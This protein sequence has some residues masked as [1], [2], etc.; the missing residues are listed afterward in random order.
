MELNVE[1]LFRRL[2]RFRRMFTRYDKLD[3]I[4]LAFI[5]FALIVDALM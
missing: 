2:K 4:F 1:K 5:Y 3:T